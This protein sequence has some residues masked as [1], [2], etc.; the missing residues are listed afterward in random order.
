MGKEFSVA[1]LAA[2]MEAVHQ[3][4]IGELLYETEGVRLR[5]RG[6][7]KAP[8]VVPVAAPVPVAVAAAPAP[9]APVAPAAPAAPAPAAEAAPAP[10][11]KEPVYIK[12]PLVG[13]FYAASGPD[14]EPYV[15]VGQP[16][17]EGQTVFIVES[18]KVMN[19]IP[20]DHSGTVAEIL[21]ENGQPVEYGQ[22]VLRLE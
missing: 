14:K 16:V 11:A 15:T 17:Q 4:Q 2:L 21:V 19:E 8:E 5:I 7:Q 20:A 1:E 9:A 22:P 10:A 3:Q 18:M 12:S 6:E 13:T